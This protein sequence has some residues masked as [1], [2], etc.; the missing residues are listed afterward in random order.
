MLDVLRKVA[1]EPITRFVAA[2][3]GLDGEVTEAVPLTTDHEPVP[4]KMVF[5]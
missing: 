1:E 2:E 4:T 5:P 3:V